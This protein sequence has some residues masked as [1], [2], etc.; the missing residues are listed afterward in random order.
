M[1]GPTRRPGSAFEHAVSPLAGALNREWRRDYEDGPGP[2]PA[3]WGAEPVL[4]RFERIFEAL[5]YLERP[6]APPGCS[7]G[8]LKALARLAAA[9]EPDAA[10]VLVQYL[11]PCLARSAVRGGPGG[12]EQRIDALISEAWEV[13][14]AGVDLRGRPV[15]IALL[16]TIE[17]RALR[18]PARAARRAAERETLVDDVARFAGSAGLAGRPVSAVPC[19]GEEL[20]A[21]LSEAG[22]VGADGRDVRLLGGLFVGWSTTRGLAAAEGVTDRSIRYRRADAIG[23]VA[24]VLNGDP[25]A[26]ADA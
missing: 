10:R 21:L 3:V 9:G 12:R 1:G 15:K 16:R 11:L 23:R 20:V 2:A 13:V 19:A 25:R 17:H 14:R 6:G 22:R 7:E 4:T 18:K 5:A 26:R 8:V 24:R